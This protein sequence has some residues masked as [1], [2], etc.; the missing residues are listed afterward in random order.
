MVQESRPGDDAV[1]R[2]LA[3]ACPWCGSGIP[4]GVNLCVV[5]GQ[6]LALPR[7]VRLASP[8]RRLAGS[9]VD[10]L[11][12]LLTLY[13]GALAWSII[14]WGQGQTPAKQLLQMRVVDATSGGVVG[15]GRVFQR[16]IV[17][18]W[19]VITFPFFVL[20]NAEAREILRTQVSVFFDFFALGAVTLMILGHAR[21]LWD[22]RRQNL[23][24]KMAGTLVVHWPDEAGPVVHHRLAAPGG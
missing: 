16:I 4:P 12:M 19:L 1:A 14:V 21:L 17:Y 15:W 2:P 3:Q 23:Y 7:G 20:S 13:I 24:D 8:G 18:Q 5:C 6:V 10:T 11:L 9:L 22:R